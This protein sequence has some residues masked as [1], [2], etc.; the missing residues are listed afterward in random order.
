MM[1]TV[2]KLQV[3]WN[4]YRIFK[5]KEINFERVVYK[6]VHIVYELLGKMIIQAVNVN[7]SMNEL[8]LHIRIFKYFQY[9]RYVTDVCSQLF[10]PLFGS[11]QGARPSAVVSI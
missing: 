11:I 2:S 5:S 9:A 1:L 10:L 6:Y 3:I 4:L 8:I 7:I